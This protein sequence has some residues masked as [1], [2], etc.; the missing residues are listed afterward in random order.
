MSPSPPPP[1]VVEP[2]ISAAHRE[3]LIAAAGG[4]V[5]S[6]LFMGETFTWK[7]AATALISG[8]FASFYGVQLIAGY[9]HLDAGYYGAIGAAFGLGAMTVLGGWFKLLNSWK[10]DPQGFI[11][12][13]LPFFRKG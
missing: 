6:L 10:D 4:S 11:S 7:A 12:K 9:F 5:L 1:E 3:I 2:I 13:F 8:L